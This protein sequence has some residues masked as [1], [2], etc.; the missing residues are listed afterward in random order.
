MGITKE[1][2]KESLLYFYTIY[3]IY[4]WSVLTIN[5]LVL[6]FNALSISVMILDSWSWIKEQLLY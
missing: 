6:I 4:E 3:S 5:N 2:K 1:L